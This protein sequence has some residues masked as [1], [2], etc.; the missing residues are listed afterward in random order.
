MSC[1]LPILVQPHAN[2]TTTA[3]QLADSCSAGMTGLVTPYASMLSLH[4]WTHETDL[5]EELEDVYL[6][7]QH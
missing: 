6:H 4:A 1:M 2:A 5:Q 3:M 7:K